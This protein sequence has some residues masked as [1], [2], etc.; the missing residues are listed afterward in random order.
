MLSFMVFLM[1]A[2]IATNASLHHKRH[3]MQNS[4]VDM[5]G[6]RNQHGRFEPPRPV[7]KI[8]PQ[9]YG[10]SLPVFV[11]LPPP[12][13]SGP[14]GPVYRLPQ[15][16][17]GSSLPVSVNGPPQ[18]EIGSTKATGI[19]DANQNNGNFYFG[20]GAKTSNNNKSDINN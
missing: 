16:G 17:C 11:N 3:S 12:P 19:F 2:V 5:N 20:T 7:Y 13:I 8:P 9:V 4:P 14:P 10:S 1:F 18:A 15:E 6:F